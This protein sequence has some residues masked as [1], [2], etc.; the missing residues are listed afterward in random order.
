VNKRQY[1]KMV[2]LRTPSRNRM[3]KRR[4]AYQ[5]RKAAAR[6]EAYALGYGPAYDVCERY[7]DTMR[8]QLLLPFLTRLAGARA[9]W[10]GAA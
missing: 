7:L 5:A 4:A 9:T 3:A 2:S 1:R 8:D 6:R 10:A